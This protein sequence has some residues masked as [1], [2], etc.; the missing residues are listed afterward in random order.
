MSKKKK[1]SVLNKVVRKVFKMKTVDEARNLMRECLESSKIND[2]DK[3]IMLDEIEQI[4]S[5]EKI[6]QYIANA[7]LAYEGDR[8]I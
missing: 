7:I 6:H 8:V 1:V 4:T 2:E 5:L 3:Q